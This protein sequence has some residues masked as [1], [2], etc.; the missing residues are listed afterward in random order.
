MI[1]S[2]CCSLAL[3][4]LSSSPVVSVVVEFTCALLVSVGEDGLRDK[5]SALA[6]LFPGLCCIVQ[7]HLLN[8]HSPPSQ[9][10]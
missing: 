5:A 3:L 1:V 6:L 8:D 4:N 10:C 9:L 7:I 2:A